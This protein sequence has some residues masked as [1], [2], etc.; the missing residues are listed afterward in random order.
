MARAGHAVRLVLLVRD[1]GGELP[2][3]GAP[4]EGGWSVEEE[5]PDWLERVA[6]LARGA[7]VV[8]SAGPYN[9]G[10]AAMVAAGEAPWWADLP[11]DPFAELQAA[12]LVAGPDE[13]VE[14]R[15]VAA[16]AFATM[17]LGD[18]DAISAISEAQRYAVI[19]QLGLL[20]RLVEDDPVLVGRERAFVLP[21]AWAF[22][23]PSRPP[24]PREPGQPLV[25]AMVGGFNTWLDEETL[26]TGLDLAFQRV[27]E[28]RVVA[29]GGGIPRHHEAGAARFAAWAAARRERVE[30]LGWSPQEALGLALSRAHVGLC[31]DRPGYEPELGS[32]T[33]LLFYAHQGMLGLASTRS[34]LA[35]ELA[36]LEALI[37]LPEGRPEALAEALA[38]VAAAPQ[39]VAALSRAQAVLADRY[40]PDAVAAPLLAWLEDPLRRA[41]GEHA[42]AALG[43]ENARLKVE[44][45]AIYRS[46]TWRALAWLHGL[47]RGSTR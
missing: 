45:S 43:R 35:Q 9:P 8:V 44:L 5:G 3:E 12:V 27:P 37:P 31:L 11:G 41:P 29:T 26:I 6:A 38:G 17:V 10:V 15:V 28:L 16:T 22:G 30:L 36:A 32:R 33:R 47:L 34:P 14:G 24:R 19:G 39:P 23:L 4:W 21:V 2:A 18:A 46:P 40:D 25:V 20:R 1:A 7:E 42:A 13:P